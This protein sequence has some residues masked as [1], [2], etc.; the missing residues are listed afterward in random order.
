MATITGAESSFYPGI[1]QQDRPYST[2]GWGLWQITPGDSAPSEYGSDYQLLDPWN[3]AE[4]AVWKYD[5]QDLDAWTA[6][7]DGAYESYLESGVTP[8]TVLTDPGEYVQVGSAPSGTP[9]S[10]VADPGSTYG[11]G[12]PSTYQGFQVAFNAASTGDLYL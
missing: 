7:Y 9:A 6:Y 2:T 10:P 1:I 5:E 11:P 4:T 8:A 12:I 3:N